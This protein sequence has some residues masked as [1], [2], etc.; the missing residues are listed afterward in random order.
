LAE[1]NEVG[2]AAEKDVLGV[3][4][5]VERGVWVGVSATADVGFAFQ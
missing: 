2:A 3:D 4:D 5:F 1:I